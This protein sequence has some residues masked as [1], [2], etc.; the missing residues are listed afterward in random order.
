MARAKR[1]DPGPR[2]KR[3]AGLPYGRE[4]TGKVLFRIRE[5]H[6]ANHLIPLMA[7]RALGAAKLDLVLRGIALPAEHVGDRKAGPGLVLPRHSYEQL[8]DLARGTAGLGSDPPDIDASREVVLLKRKWV[9]E[10]L[11]RL[12][13]LGLIRRVPQTGRRPTLMILKDDGSREPF[14]DPDGQ[15][16]DTYATVLGTVIASGTLAK[17]GVPELSAYLAA[18]VAERHDRSARSKFR[19]RYPLGGGPWF[20][21]LTWFAD[22]ERRFGPDSRVLLPFSVPTLQ[23]GIRSLEKAGLLSHT[24][25][26]VAPRT[27]QRLKQRRNLYRNNFTIL[28]APGPVLKPADYAKEVD[29]QTKPDG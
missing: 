21:P 2:R 7:S 22:Q 9:G 15:E 19:G 1:S 28:K 14:D 23:R 13:A 6:I 29:R 8:H 4:I 26:S 12:E 18:T 10:Q 27:Q 3:Q 17:W 25:I 16:G 11:A 24:Q 5:T 20:R